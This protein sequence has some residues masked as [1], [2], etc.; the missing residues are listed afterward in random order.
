[1]SRSIQAKLLRVVEDKEFERVGG[2]RTQRSDVR[3]IAA[4]NLDLEEAISRGEFRED[5][6]YRLNIIP[7]VLP[8]LRERR[9]DVPY[10]ARHFVGRIGRD[11][12][13]APREL[14]PA[15]LEVFGRAP[16]AGQRAR[17][18]SRDPPRPR[19]LLA[20]RAGPDDFAWIAAAARRQRRH[21]AR[22]GGPRRAPGSSGRGRLP[23]GAGRLRPPPGPGRP[24]R[25]ATARSARPRGSSASPATRSRPSSTGTTSNRRNKRIAPPVDTH[26]AGEYTSASRA[27]GP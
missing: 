23:G 1:M 4:T 15:V 25:R 12:G 13:Q 19:A 11:L 8:P 2:T 10:L 20:A 18:G 14:D 16:L 7:I 27:V 24:R 17:A 5:L 22:G 21:T 9:E 3:V 6:Y 26:R